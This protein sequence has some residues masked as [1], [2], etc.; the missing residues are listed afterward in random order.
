MCGYRAKLTRAL[1]CL[2]VAAVATPTAHV[3]T[4]TTL[5]NFG[6]NPKN[7]SA[8]WDSCQQRCHSPHRQPKGQGLGLVQ[9][10]SEPQV[11]LGN[12]QGVM[13]QAV[14]MPLLLGAYTPTPTIPEVH[15]ISF[16]LL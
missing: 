7:R 15:T 5:T 12:V 10:R 2:A 11:A 6:S 9:T 8:G 1:S 3:G 13:P 16:G 14:L 4:T